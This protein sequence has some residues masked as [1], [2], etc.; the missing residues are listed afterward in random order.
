MAAADFGSERGFSKMPGVG[1]A[2]PDFSL[3]DH[4]GSEASPWHQPLAFPAL[5]FCFDSDDSAGVIE[6]PQR[7]W[8]EDSDLVLPQGRIVLRVSS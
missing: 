2:V 1:D 5:R 6:D 7:V 4:T 3:K 8:Q